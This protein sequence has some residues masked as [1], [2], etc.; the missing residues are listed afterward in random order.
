MLPLAGIAFTSMHSL[1]DLNAGNV[2]GWPLHPSLVDNYR[3]V[4]GESRLGASGGE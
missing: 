3:T 2:W 1:A 4:L